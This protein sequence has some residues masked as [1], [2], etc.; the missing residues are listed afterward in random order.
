MDRQFVASLLGQTK[1]EE[2]LDDIISRRVDFL[3]DYQNATYAKR[4]RSR[5]ERIRAVE[6]RV[7]PGHAELTESVA[8]DSHQRM[9]GRHGLTD[10]EIEAAENNQCDAICKPEFHKHPDGSIVCFGCER[11]VTLVPPNDKLA[12]L[13]PGGDG[14]AGGKESNVK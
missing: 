14:G 5:V 7:M 10:D 3:T 6:A 4:Y 1:K 12:P 2:T 9:V 13:T 8:G 11:M